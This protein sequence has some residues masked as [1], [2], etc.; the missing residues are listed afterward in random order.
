MPVEKMSS[1]KHKQKLCRLGLNWQNVENN[2]SIV[3]NLSSKKL[4]N[5]EINLLNKGLGF[6]ILPGKFF[7]S[8][9]ESRKVLPGMSPVPAKTAQD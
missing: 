8:T 3:T 4:V 1:T 6:G 2:L 7:T 9:R 5:N